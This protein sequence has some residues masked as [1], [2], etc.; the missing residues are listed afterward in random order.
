MSIEQIVF[1][2][3]SNQLHKYP[4]KGIYPFPGKSSAMT[5]LETKNTDTDNDEKKQQKQCNTFDLN[6]IA[7]EYGRWRKSHPFDCGFCT[8]ATLSCAPNVS[9]M[10]QKA[11]EYNQKKTKSFAN[12]KGSIFKGMKYF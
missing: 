10:K 7:I 4:S 12:D 3:T 5:R 6:P 11:F 2:N 8:D 1:G 9:K